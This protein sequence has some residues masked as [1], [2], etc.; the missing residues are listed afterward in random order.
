[1]V[2][3]ST[4]EGLGIELDRDPTEVERWALAATLYGNRISTQ[5]ATHTYRVLEDAGVRTIEDAGRRS[6][7]EL[8]ALLDE[9]GYVRYDERTASRLLALAR[10]VGDRHGGAPPGRGRRDAPRPRTQRARRRRKAG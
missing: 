3:R 8:V 10:V 2:Q 9:D 1:V 6:W 7:D 5:I 4:D